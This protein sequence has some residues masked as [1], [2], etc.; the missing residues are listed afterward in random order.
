M[1][2]RAGAGDDYGA[3]EAA[4]LQTLRSAAETALPEALRPPPWPSA[5]AAT[6]VHEGLK[7]WAL[8]CP[9]PLVVF[10]DEIDALRGESLIAIL[11]QLRGGFPDRPTSFP[12]SVV[13]CGLRDVRD[14]KMASGGDPSRLGTSSPF[15]V[16][17]ESL[18]IGDFTETEVKALLLQHTEAS[19]QPFAEA[20]L[21]HAFALT[22]GQPWLVNALAREVVE[23]I[24]V[25]SP[26]PIEEGHLD[27]AKERL[28]LARATHLDSLVSKLM[29]P[30]VRRVIAPILEGD[31]AA[32]DP[33]Y[34]DDVAYVRDLGL[35]APTPPARPANPIYREVIVRVL[36]GGAEESVTV[37]PR[38]FVLP[39]G[40][41]DF[42]RLLEEFADFWRQH[43]ALLASRM[44]RD[45][46][47]EGLRQLNSY[48]EGL[49]LDEGV[50][51][52]F[53]RRP[54]IPPAEDRTRFE[55]AYTA[56]G[57]RVTVLRG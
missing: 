44:G 39:D 2:A 23:K 55:E 7:A 17:L 53:D 14:Y 35:I 50:L 18:R 16:K 19:G 37:D 26:T 45:P 6:R 38:S 46:F 41:L 24:R 29:E 8:A 13:L 1:R 54:D 11:R 3:A 32:M 34:Q 25:P 12:S 10:F 47:E 9:R 31:V 40:R 30:R 42:R 48:L 52:I 43:G 21:A 15:N 27:E 4:V 56:K 51:V 28:I 36:A 57:R 22:Q 5:A 33:T 20:A 49:G